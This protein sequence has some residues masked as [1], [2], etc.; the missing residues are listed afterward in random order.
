MAI[1]FDRAADFYDQTR[2]LPPEV[3]DQVTECILRLSRATPETT[4]FE[5]GIGT[6]R[7][8]LPLVERG[9][10][11]T[12][13]DISEQMM[14]KLRQKLVGKPHQLT[15]IN[16]DITTL[17][18]E[19]G[20]FDVAIAAHILHLV[21][22][23]R[24]ALA[25]IQ[26]VLKPQ[27]VLIYFHH[28]GSGATRNDPIDQQWRTI[29]ERYSYQADFVGAVTEDVLG[30]FQAQN[31]AIET[32]SVAELPRIRTAA[33]ALQTYCDR[34]YSNLWQIPEPIFTPAIEDL[35]TWVQQTYPDLNERFE[36]SYEVTVTA[37]SR[38]R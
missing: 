20:V 4:F 17:P 7:I 31:L 13:V 8:A 27:G 23:W 36:S 33:E 25:E 22:D 35:K 28:P 30:Y 32:V 16:A 18:L 19:S 15:L 5:P 1:S 37:A 26:R 21:A 6:G 10:A 2:A 3:A 38:A 14:D 24:S 11:Y 12:G 29:L 34:I 9:Y